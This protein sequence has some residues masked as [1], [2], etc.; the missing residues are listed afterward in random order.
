MT[1]AFWY[2]LNRIR[3]IACGLNGSFLYASIAFD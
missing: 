3:A 1:T 2:A